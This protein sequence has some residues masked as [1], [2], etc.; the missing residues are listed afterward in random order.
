MRLLNIDEPLLRAT[1]YHRLLRLFLGYVAVVTLLYGLLTLRYYR[2]WTVADWLINYAGGFL[3]RGLAG[4]VA[5]QLGRTL[6]VSPILFIALALV[7]SYAV[8]LLCVK[9]LAWD[10]RPC[11]WCLALLVS[12]ATLS[13]QV[14]DPTGG[15]RKEI[16]FLATLAGVLAWGGK[17][18]GS[19]LTIPLVGTPLVAALVLSHESLVCFTPYLVAA[20]CIQG[21]R[22]QK[23]I[24]ACSL[25][26]T[27]GLLLALLSLE[28]L[29]DAATAKSICA[30]LG[31]PLL[32]QGKAICAGGAIGYLTSTPEMARARTWAV[33]RGDLY[34]VVYPLAT[35][36][37]LLPLVIGSIAL[38]RRGWEREIRIVWGTAVLSFVASLPLFIYAEDW[39][40]WIYIHVLSLTLLLL[41]LAR[42]PVQENTGPTPRQSETGPRRRT[43]YA[44]A[45]YATLWS[46]P[47]VPSR[48]LPFGYLGLLHYLGL[49]I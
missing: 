2:S 10:A 43:W 37:A 32:P 14:L 1:S 28:H 34:F 9:R 6:H 8:L 25:P 40:R 30:S 38:V 48:M 36:L 15:F 23:A 17:L 22:F 39:G 45:A 3:R 13:F 47:H 29:G 35:A 44:L 26:L 42:E 49:Y 18:N 20:L 27:A 24:V 31:Y 41:A 7:S 19:P 11:W 46:L 16:L 12:P 33:V 21:R 4:Q 5:W